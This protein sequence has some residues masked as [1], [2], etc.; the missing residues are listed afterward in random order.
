MC[1]S[2]LTNVFF[3]FSLQFIKDLIVVTLRLAGSLAR[4]TRHHW[5]FM[6]A[7]FLDV[8]V[9]YCC[10]S[11]A[12][13]EIAAKVALAPLSQK[14]EDDK[15]SLLKFPD[16]IIAKLKSSPG[17]TIEI[18]SLPLSQANV[19]WFLKSLLYH[20]D[21]TPF[22]VNAL[23]DL[24]D[25]ISFII[26]QDANFLLEKKAALDLLWKLIYL[27]HKTNIISHP[28]LNAQLLSLTGPQE[29][30][31]QKMASCVLW[32]LYDNDHEGTYKS[33]LVTLLN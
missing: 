6:D 31:L 16:T 32:K 5:Q 8:V 28:D 21:F 13:I 1:S 17:V 33:V 23:P 14:I 30:S 20:T 18:F 26:Q 24:L 9:P 2:V 19:L 4:E 15:F 25:S 29:E 11:M 22:I 27:G 3:L 12:N 10:S 7:D